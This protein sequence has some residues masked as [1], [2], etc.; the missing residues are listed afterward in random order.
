M[1]M[2]D[3]YTGYYST[4][5]KFDSEKA[6]EIVSDGNND[7]VVVVNGDALQ[8]HILRL[9]ISAYDRI[10]KMERKRMSE[11]VIKDGVLL[12][13]LA[14]T[15]L[16]TTHVIIEGSHSSRVILGE[17]MYMDSRTP[18]PEVEN[19]NRSYTY[20]SQGGANVGSKFDLIIEVF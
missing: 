16:D 9:T 11:Y 4:R 1:I 12:Q 3:R 10:N 17:P 6:R 15:D 2:L 13:R 5:I 7:S 18:L 19:A 20:Y 8:G 14:P